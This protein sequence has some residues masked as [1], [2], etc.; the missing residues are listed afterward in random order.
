MYKPW[1]ETRHKKI[2]VENARKSPY[3]LFLVGTAFPLIKTTSPTNVI[4]IPTKNPAGIF[5]LYKK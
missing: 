1:K 2:D 3:R 4:T 5:S